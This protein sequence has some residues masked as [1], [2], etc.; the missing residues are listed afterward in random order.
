MPTIQ[1]AKKIIPYTEGDDG[2]FF[3]PTLYHTNKAGKQLWWRIWT[4]GDV[5]YA[6]GGQQDGKT[7]EFPPVECKGKNI[8]RTNETSPEEQALCD[9][10]TKWTK[11]QDQGYS[12]SKTEQ[13][14]TIILPM[15]ANKFED[16]KHVIEYPWL[17]SPKIDGVR[18]IARLIDGQ[19]TLQSRQGTFWQQMQPLKEQLTRIFETYPDLVLDGEIYSHT[20]P[21]NA[22]SGAARS[23]KKPSAYENGLEYWIFDIIDTK[24]S[25]KTRHARLKKFKGKFKSCDKL[26]WVLSE[27]VDN[28]DDIEQLHRTYVSQGFEGIIIRNPDSKYLLK[29]RSSDLLKFKYFVDEEYEVVNVLKGKGTEEGAVVFTC[30]TEDGQEFNVRPRGSIAKRRWQYANKHMYIGKQLTVRWQRSDDDEE[31]PRFP[32][33]IKF[34]K[35]VESCEPVDFRDY[36]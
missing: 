30:V 26:R 33:G 11:K 10:H 16:K 5:I 2:E 17:A 19:I 23:Q 20:L 21:F 24:L 32:A 12:T 7:R 35:T 3:F 8:G 1:I 29:Y 22:I 28:E 9:A 4:L 18:C 15:L 34:P 25:Y 36:E 14:T 31:V 13:K 27:E 6:E